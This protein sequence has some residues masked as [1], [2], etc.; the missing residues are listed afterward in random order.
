M[1]CNKHHSSYGMG[2]NSEVFVKNI[3]TNRKWGKIE[4][5]LENKQKF[6]IWRHL[7]RL[8]SSKLFLDFNLFEFS[9]NTWL[10]FIGFIEIIKVI[11]VRFELQ[12]FKNVN[13]ANYGQLTLQMNQYVSQIFLLLNK[14]KVIKSIL[15]WTVLHIFIFITAAYFYWLELS[16]IYHANDRNNAI[17]EEIIKVKSSDL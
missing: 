13:I 1:R 8:N 5:L 15:S 17:N 14:I 11:N 6:L 2:S 4:P 12:L 7:C 16:T 10:Y 9:K 3:M